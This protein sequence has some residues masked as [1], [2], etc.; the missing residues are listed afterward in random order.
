VKKIFLTGLYKADYHVANGGRKMKVKRFF[1]VITVF[2]AGVTLVWATGRSDRSSGGGTARQYPQGTA[3]N[4]VKLNMFVNFP[5]FQADAWEGIIPEAIT[6]KTG[7]DIEMTKAVDAQQLPLMIAS[8]E[9]PDLIFTDDGTS[10]LLSRLASPQFSYAYNDLIN[11]YC[12]EWVP[13]PVYVYNSKLYNRPNDNNFYWILTAFSSQKEWK[14]ALGPGNEPSLAVRQDILDKMGN[15]KIETLDDFTNVLGMVKRQYPDMIPYLAGNIA[16]WSNQALRIW[17]G[18]GDNDF[19]EEDGKVK[20]FINSRNYKKYLKYV[21]DLYR[22]GYVQADNYAL[23]DDN[24]SSL[25][26]TGK[27]FSTS[28]LTSGEAYLSGTRLAMTVPGAEF[29]ELPP[30]SKDAQ[31]YQCGTGWA[32][33]VIAKNCKNPQAAI[34]FMQ[35]LW[36]DEGMKLTEWGRRGIEWTPDAN[37]NPIFSQEWLDASKNSDVFYKKYNP[38]FYI[39]MKMVVEINGRMAV[40][41]EKYREV[42]KQITPYMYTAPWLSAASPKGS[43]PEQLILIKLNDMV[44][45]AEVKCWLSNTD[46]E[47]E[48]NYNQLMRDA[49]T[50]GVDTIEKYMEVNV[51]NFRTIYQQ[52]EAQSLSGN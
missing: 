36:S 27:V 23:N 51:P 8:G 30:L 50:I 2:L 7:V 1:F 39:S 34:K 11:A 45:N 32:G 52:M 9:L 38:A 20:Y 3:E 33:I 19:I 22:A 5:W 41:P 21:N 49:Q 10:G 28:T 18:V 4:P 46:A 48:A 12:P 26:Q 6:A 42:Y 31:Y 40:I 24:L 25:V 29:R 16:N 13:D 35:Y 47:F 17:N 37:G 43:S 44:R 14:D 15:P